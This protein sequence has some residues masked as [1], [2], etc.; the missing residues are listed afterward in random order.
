MANDDDV[1]WYDD[2]N[3]WIEHQRNAG[4]FR[5]YEDECRARVMFRHFPK[6]MESVLDNKSIPDVP[7]RERRKKGPQGI[8]DAC[9]ARSEESRRPRR[10]RHHHR[11]GRGAHDRRGH[12]RQRRKS[13]GRGCKMLRTRNGLPKHCAGIRIAT[14]SG[15]SASARAASPPI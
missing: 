8:A 4:A 13:V 2:E 6:I 5:N 10:C 3:V 12:H 7:Q 1:A 11:P 9:T 15:A 14:A